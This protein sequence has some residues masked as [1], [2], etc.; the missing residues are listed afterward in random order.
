MPKSKKNKSVEYAIKYLSEIQKKD[1]NTIALELEIPEAIVEEVIGEKSEPKAKRTSKS[2]K[3]MIRQTSNK[4]INNVSIMT[5]AASQ[6]NDELKKNMKN[7][8][9]RTAKNSIFRPND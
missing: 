5:E 3:L 2:Q 9:S 1:I 6:L 8:V 4:Q 7:S